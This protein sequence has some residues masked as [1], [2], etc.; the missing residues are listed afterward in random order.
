LSSI[1]ESR[2]RLDAFEGDAYER[3]ST[4]VLVSGAAELEAFVHVLRG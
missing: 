1:E 4:T 3:V 2:G